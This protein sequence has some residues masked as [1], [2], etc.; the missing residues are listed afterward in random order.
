MEVLVYHGKYGIELFDAST[1]TNAFMFLFHKL[2]REG[3][4][5]EEEMS[6]WQKK[7]W[8]QIQLGETDAL[9]HFMI[10]RKKYEYEYWEVQRVQNKDDFENFLKD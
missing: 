9:E 6:D 2:K 1:K 10:S 7:L 5:I 4:Y 3:Y 8:K